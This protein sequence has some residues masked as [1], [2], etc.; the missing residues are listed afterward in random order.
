MPLSKDRSSGEDGTEDGCD[1]GTVPDAGL[2]GL[3]DAK[4]RLNATIR[5]L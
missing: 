5:Q 1:A 2:D 3:S 4:P